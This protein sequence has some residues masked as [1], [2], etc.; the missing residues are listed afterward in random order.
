MDATSQSVSPRN[1]ATPVAEPGSGSRGRFSGGTG[2]TAVLMYGAGDGNDTVNLAPGA[3]VVLQLAPDAGD[4]SV[5]F[6][7]QGTVVHM[8]DASVT[9]TGATGSIGI[10]GSDGILNLVAPEPEAEVLASAQ[11]VDMAV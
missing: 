6:T 8:G 1:G 5:E 11:T 7:D 4:Y 9:F 10:M 2:G 3:Q